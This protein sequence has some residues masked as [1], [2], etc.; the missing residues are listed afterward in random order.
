M[1]CL[2]EQRGR[3]LARNSCRNPWF[4]TLNARVTKEFPAIRGQSLELAVDVYNLLNLI[5]PE[6]G[7]SRYHGLTFGTDLV[8]LTGY[9]TTNSRG[10]YL[11]R[12]PIYNKVE[13]FASRWQME[14]SA[15]FAF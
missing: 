1:P 12:P 8:T 15:R 2:R 10:I 9:D 14:I 6:W 11:F 7:L 3:I 5:Y 13:D 4:G